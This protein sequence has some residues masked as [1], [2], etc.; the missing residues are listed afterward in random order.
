VAPQHVQLSLVFSKSS[1][2]ELQSQRLRPGLEAIMLGQC[3]IAGECGPAEVPPMSPV[4]T[5]RG[6]FEFA[7]SGWAAFRCIVLFLGG[8][9]VAHFRVSPTGVSE[10]IS[11]TTV[12]P[13]ATS[14][15]QCVLYTL[16]TLQPHAALPAKAQHTARTHAPPKKTSKGCGAQPIGDRTRSI[17][18]TVY[19]RLCVFY[20][21]DLD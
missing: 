9:R 7:H 14:R 16:R 15:I 2:E 13:P 21:L 19:I 1:R 10:P 6:S 12:Q 20:P 3:V 11:V 8:V 18:L 5:T 17:A 4:S